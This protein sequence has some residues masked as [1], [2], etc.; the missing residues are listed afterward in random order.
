M[1][2]CKNLC[3]NFKIAKKEKGLFNSIKS[4]FKR[5]YEIKKALDNVSFTINDGDIVGYLGPNGAGKSTTIKIMCGILTP[6]SGTCTINGKIPY[7]DR[8]KYVKDIGVVFGQRSQ[9]WWDVPVIDSFQLLKDIFKIS[10]ENYEKQLK[11]LTEKLD[12]KDLLHIPLRQLSLGQKMR[13]E[14][15]A[16]LLHNPKILF[17]DEPTIG[18]DATSK[19]KVREFIKEINKTLGVTVIL[20]THDMNDIEALTNKIII[21]GKGQILYNGSFDEIKQKYKNNKTIE[22]EF[23]EEYENLNIDKFEHIKSEGKIQTFKTTDENF[24]LADFITELSKNYKVID[25]QVNS[26]SLEEIISK[27]FEDLGV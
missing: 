14:L 24:H 1:I 22:I 20:T 17:L 16:S 6:T 27:M 13:C 5:K 9:L 2:E 12:L 8:T 21:I 4:I 15:A 18:L 26:I 10:N 19:L 23:E 7:K 25:V 11:L 3:K